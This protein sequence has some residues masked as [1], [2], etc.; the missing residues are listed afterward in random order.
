[1]SLIHLFV[2]QR[3]AFEAA[4]ED[5]DWARLAPFFHPDVRYE[6]MN[7]P[8]HCVLE[9]RD[10]MVA[11]IRR[12]ITGFDKHCRRTV[13]L[14][15]V[16]REEGAN[17]IIFSR[18]MFERPGAPP[19]SSGVWEIATYCEGR[20]SRLIDLYEPNAAGDY[21]RWMAEWGQGL[22]PSYA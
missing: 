22:D 11:G 19:L 16:V 4:Y 8:F 1:M 6:V 2:A 14:D 9:G 7:M 10:A 3:E 17:V 20:I 5:D 13:G 18:M 15:R 12:S 21:Q